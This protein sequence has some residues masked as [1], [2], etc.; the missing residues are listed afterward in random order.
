MRVSSA[1]SDS[2]SA[3]VVGIGAVPAVSS[4]CGPGDS[5]P[6]GAELQTR[7]LTSWERQQQEFM[8]ECT[9]S[10][11]LNAN[12]RSRSV[13]AQAWKP[14]GD[15]ARHRPTAAAVQ[16]VN[17]PIALA[18]G[19]DVQPRGS[20]QAS[21][22]SDGGAKAPV[23]AAAH[24]QFV[25]APMH[26]EAARARH[27]HLLSYASAASTKQQHTDEPRLEVGSSAD[28]AE[29]QAALMECDRQQQLLQQRLGRRAVSSAVQPNTYTAPA[30]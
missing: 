13:V 4:P 9:F 22:L 20:S 2:S 10:P 3:D 1:G 23:P 7:G 25:T 26:H 18:D 19:N 6:H 17:A 27:R 24:A 14:A 11:R 5:S 12:A 8:Q 29:I 28:E 15:G 21:G 30:R 16:S